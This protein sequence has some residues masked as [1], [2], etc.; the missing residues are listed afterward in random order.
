M[1]LMTGG[2]SGYIGVS[3]TESGA[4]VEA[5]MHTVHG[6][7]H[8]LSICATERIRYLS[9]DVK[10]CGSPLLVKI[11]VRIISRPYKRQE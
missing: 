10:S 1:N 5:R 7:Y 11:K 2:P 4:K 9:G 6:V 3:L 8:G